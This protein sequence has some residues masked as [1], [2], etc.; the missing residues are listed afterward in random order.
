MGKNEVVKQEQKS[1]SAVLTDALMDVSG[2]LPGDFNIP[3]FVQNSVAL[4]NE[5]TQLAEFARKNG[6]T[7]IKQGLLK[8]AY[9]GLDAMNK[10]CYLIPYGNTLSFMIDYRGNVKLAKKYSIR[11]ILDIYA[12]VVRDGDDFEEVI[13]NGIATINFKP[14]PFNN[15][16]IIGAFA[17]CVYEDGGLMYEA[18]SLVDLENTRKSSKASNSPAWTRFTRE[19]Y[20]KTVLHRL[21]KNIELDFGNNEQRKYFMEDMEINTDDR[22]NA[23]TEEFIIEEPIP[24]KELEKTETVENNEIIEQADVEDWQKES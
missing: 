20:K 7:Q 22:E 24:D 19:M 14:L 18:M 15:A 23:N 13:N 11:P 9:L 4:L 1:F 3:R 8:G 21:C 2:V 6:T 12:K 10:E 16:G 5:N 17:V